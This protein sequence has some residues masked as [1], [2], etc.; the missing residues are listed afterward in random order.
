MK[1]LLLCFSLI[2]LTSTINAQWTS[3][4]TGFSAASRGL[5]EIKIVDA[6]TVWGIAYDGSGLGLDIQEFTVTTNGGDSWNPGTIDVGNT[7]LQITNISPVSGTTAWVG[8]FDSTNGLGGVFKTSNGG[9]TWEQ[10][11]S[12]A[13][14]TPGVS[15]FN[16][17][18]FFNANV[19]LTMGDPIGSGLGE[20]E[21][22]KTIDGGDNWTAIS[23]TALPNPL[24]GEYGYN[25]G[26]AAA[27]GSFWFTTNKGRVYRTTDQGVTWTVS[28]APITDFGGEAQ[29]GRIYFSNANNGYLQKN[30]VSG[31]VTTRTYSTTTNGGATWSTPV[32]FTGTRFILNYIP[33]TTTM[34]AT[35]QAAPVG[36]SVSTDN[37]A[38]WTD[39]EPAGT[40][41]RGASAFL[42]STTGWCAGFNTD[43]LTDGVF[44]L[45]GTLGTQNF[46]NATKFKVYP[47]PAS[48]MVTISAANVDSYKLSVT[49]ITGKVVMTKSLNGIENTLDISSLSTG[50]YFFEL[51]SD[52]IK[53]V[54]KILKN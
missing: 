15:W 53:D 11:N 39:L 43:P 34:V 37:G 7:T 8:A 23:A 47:N 12:S 22:Y 16:V 5:T 28:Q 14:T 30:V 20:F 19:G 45:T 49:D 18:H 40:E 21:I 42:N 52:N 3:Q 27:G 26:Y 32:P 36:T 35:S 46:E 29:N 25:G 6:N 48:S 51:S 44:K 2:A 50:A 10:Q 54:V 31:A 9:S 41:Q 24:S 1:K 4:A 17:V 13:Y 33:G 38:T